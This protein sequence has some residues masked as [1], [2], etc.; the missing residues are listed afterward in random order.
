M[1]FANASTLYV[2]DEGQAG[3]PGPSDFSGGVYTQ[4]IPANNPSAGLQKWVNSQPD[5]SG[6]WTLAY[7]LTNGLNL[8]V[9][10]SYTIANYPTGTNS[11][12]GV[13]WQPANNGLRN[14]AGQINGDGTVTIYAATSTISGETD[15][16]AD[17]NEVVAITDTL[18]ATSLPS[19]ESFTVLENANGLDAYRGVALSAPYTPNLA[20]TFSSA[21]VA[22]VTSD[23]YTANG[24]TLD[25]ITLDFAPTTGQVLTLV[26]NTGAGAVVGTFTGLLQG[27]TVT[28][29]YGGNT[30]YFTIS[31]TGGDGNDITLTNQPAP[32]PTVIQL[33]G[34]SGVRSPVLSP[35]KR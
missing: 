26:N 34:T 18:S 10:Y 30:Y 35:R 28:G 5:G 31:Y 11:A 7:T 24:V 17:P 9:P 6:T 3:V 27:S 22:P 2:T 21:T 20:V 16:G 8:G 13:P 15:Q 33:Q 25:P 32:V 4:A 1:F 29:S 19:G 14:I 23:G 12:T